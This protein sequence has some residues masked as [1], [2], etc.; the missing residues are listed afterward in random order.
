[1][2][3]PV[4]LL[5]NAIPLALLALLLL[6]APL[7]AREE[8][9][10]QEVLET[11]YTLG[12]GDRLKI[13]VFRE[14]QLTG[15]FQVDGSGRISFPL[16]GEVDARG[17]TIRQF[18]T[19]LTSRLKEGYL[20]DPK[21]SIEV[22][23][24]RPFYILGEVNKPGKYEYLSGITLYNAIAL[25]GGYTHRALENRAEITRANPQRVIG[26]AEH[27]TVILPGDIINIRERFF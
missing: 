6:A 5:R 11:I 18:A 20:V 24:Y 21:I 27:G 12:S 19:E 15:E 22:L 2:F 26:D 16:V 10:A 3:V 23:N 25:A 17:L 1:M 7:M 9:P 14:D 4:N 8:K 13:N